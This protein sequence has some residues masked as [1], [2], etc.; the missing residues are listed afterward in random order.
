MEGEF[1]MSSSKRD[2]FKKMAISAAGSIVGLIIQNAFRP[3][4]RTTKPDTRLALVVS[5]ETK[6]YLD[7]ARAFSQKGQ[8]DWAIAASTDAIRS[9]PTLAAAYLQR[10]WAYNQ[11]RQYDQAIMDCTEAIRLDPTSVTA[12]ANRGWAYGQQ[13]RFA[14]AVSDCAE[15]IRLDPNFIPAYDILSWAQTQR[16]GQ[17]VLGGW[18][19]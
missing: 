9:Q 16:Q 7:R 15:A 8:F 12:Y 10:G 11:L 4:E 2:L 3:G 14:Q 19:R 1:T 6:E 5:T 18:S 13:G 17:R